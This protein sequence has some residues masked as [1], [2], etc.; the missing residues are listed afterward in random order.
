MNIVLLRN[1]EKKQ[2]R[3]WGKGLGSCKQ[4]RGAGDNVQTLLLLL[5]LRRVPRHTEDSLQI[6]PRM[7]NLQTQTVMPL[8]LLNPE[9]LVRK[10]KKWTTLSIFPP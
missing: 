9:E 3:A 6:P 4:W 2:P 1:N 7:P 5:L 10:T 8:A